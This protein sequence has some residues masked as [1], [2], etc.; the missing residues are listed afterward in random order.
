MAATVERTAH[1]LGAALA[2]LVA[3]VNPEVI[4][5]TGWANGPLGD[6][7]LPVVRRRVLDDAPGDAAVDLA[8]EVS[9]SSGMDGIAAIALERFMRDVGLVTTRVLPAL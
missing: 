4:A 7:M 5:L 1:Y 2:D 6:R 3:I 8:I 9:S